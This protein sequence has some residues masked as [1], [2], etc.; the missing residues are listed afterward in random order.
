MLQS[1]PTCS[2]QSIANHQISLQGKQSK[3]RQGKVRQGK[4]RVGKAR[5]GKARQGKAKQSEAKQ[6]K[7][8]Q[9]KA[10]QRLPLA[11][12]VLVRITLR[13]AVHRTLALPILRA[14]YPSAGSTQDPF[15][16][17]GRQSA[18]HRRPV[19]ATPTPGTAPSSIGSSRS[20]RSSPF[21]GR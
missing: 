5:Q 3:A 15:S 13:L 19:L 21:S 11:L 9:S 8:K 20:L 18:Q 12:P 14:Q 7:A 4:A 1:A 17:T 16:R 2:A 6:S 10:K